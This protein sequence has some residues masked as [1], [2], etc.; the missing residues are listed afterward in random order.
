MRKTGEQ[1]HAWQLLREMGFADA[2][3]ESFASNIQ[4][5]QLLP[6]REPA[7]RHE[8]AEL[9]QRLMTAK[10]AEARTTNERW[11]NAN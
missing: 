2:F 1:L 7:V 10:R 6:R 11:S 8:D 3:A 4:D 5:G 9:F